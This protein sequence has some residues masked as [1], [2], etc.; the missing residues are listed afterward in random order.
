[1]LIETHVD[2]S[3]TLTFAVDRAED[4][5]ISIGFVGFPW[6]VHPCLLVSAFGPTDEAATE[7]FKNAVLGN[8]L[9]IAIVRKGQEIADVF[10]TGDPDTEADGLSDDEEL[11]LRYWNGRRWSSGD[12]AL[13]FG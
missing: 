3:G 6:H 1:M 4:G 2:L 5:T 11:E 9:V 8:R 13:P 10:I 12:P 7:G